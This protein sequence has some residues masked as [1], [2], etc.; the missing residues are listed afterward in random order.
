MGIWV[1]LEE[2]KRGQEGGT[3]LRLKK[4]R[5]SG[6]LSTVIRYGWA[7]EEVD[8]DWLSFSYLTGY[9]GGVSDMYHG[10][11]DLQAWEV[12]APHALLKVLLIVFLVATNIRQGTDSDHMQAV[13]VHNATTLSRLSPVSLWW[14]ASV[15]IITLY[16]HLWS[17]GSEGVVYC[18]WLNK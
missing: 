12:R 18:D 2:V 11:G 4:E 7:K 15:Y 16:V 14:C 10:R 13:L 6:R 8:R 5:S 1:Y 9:F 3:L 17:A